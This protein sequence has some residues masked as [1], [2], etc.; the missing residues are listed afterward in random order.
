MKPLAAF[1][2]GL[3]LASVAVSA[4]GPPPTDCALALAGNT[5]GIRRECRDSLRRLSAEMLEER[6]VKEA[7]M[8]RVVEL[9]ASLRETRP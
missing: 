6:R 7:A 1:L 2:L 5:D 4:Y 9:E 8:A 3:L